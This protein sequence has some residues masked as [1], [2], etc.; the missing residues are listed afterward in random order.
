MLL[1]GVPPKTN[2]ITCREPCVGTKGKYKIAAVNHV[3]ST[4]SNNITYRQWS[5]VPGTKRRNG[6]VAGLRGA[7]EYSQSIPRIIS[8]YIGFRPIEHFQYRYCILHCFKQ[9]Q[10]HVS[11]L[12]AEWLLHAL[13]QCQCL[14]SKCTTLCLKSAGLKTLFWIAARL[15]QVAG[16]I[17]IPFAASRILHRTIYGSWKITYGNVVKSLFY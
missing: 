12:G 7:W 8:V 17:G 15:L 5:R 1:V 11:D 9:R 13:Q 3:C 10:C 16:R 14:D 6:R 2:I 4:D